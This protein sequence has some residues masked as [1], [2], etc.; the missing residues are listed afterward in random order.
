MVSEKNYHQQDSYDLED[1]LFGLGTGIKPQTVN[2]KRSSDFI[3]GDLNK[4]RTEVFKTSPLY[5]K[6]MTKR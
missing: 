6:N 4:I 1:I 2:L 5:R 3:I